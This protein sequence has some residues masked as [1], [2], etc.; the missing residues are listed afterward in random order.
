MLAMASESSK[1][2][3]QFHVG[4]AAEAFAAAVT[5]IGAESAPAASG[6]LVEVHVAVAV[7]HDHPLPDIAV[8]FNP[9]AARS[10]TVIGAR[11]LD[12]PSL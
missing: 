7:M 10:L 11:A 1:K 2:M 12:G 5:V 6:P 8:M 4:V 9:D 3:S